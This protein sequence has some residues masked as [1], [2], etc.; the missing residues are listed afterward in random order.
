MKITCSKACSLRGDAYAGKVGT[1]LVGKLA[2]GFGRLGLGTGK[3][4]LKVKIAKK[5]LKS[6]RKRLRTKKQR[7]KGV[8]FSI[9]VTASDALGITVRT[10]RTFTVKG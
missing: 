8:K 2:R 1:S 4:T 7:R 6:Y 3:R 10:T 9:V 5:Y